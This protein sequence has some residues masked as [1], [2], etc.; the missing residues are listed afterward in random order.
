MKLW[1]AAVETLGDSIVARIKKPIFW[2]CSLHALI[3]CPPNHFISPFQFLQ[4]EKV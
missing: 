2:L 3:S 1:G 4:H